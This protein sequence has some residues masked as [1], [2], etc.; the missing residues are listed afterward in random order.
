MGQVAAPYIL[1]AGFFFFFLKSTQFSIFV[2]FSLFVFFSKMNCQ[3]CLNNFEILG[4]IY[5]QCCE[6]KQSSIL[7]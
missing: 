7:K 3:E 6:R 4:A 1:I 5:V 2:I